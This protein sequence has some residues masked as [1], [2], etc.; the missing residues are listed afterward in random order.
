MK[1]LITPWAN[2]LENGG[3]SLCGFEYAE[4]THA[5]VEVDLSKK[6]R[7]FIRSLCASPL[8]LNPAATDT[9]EVKAHKKTTLE[10][11]RSAIKGNEEAGRTLAAI[12]L[13]T[14]DNYVRVGSDFMS[15]FNIVTLKDNEQPYIQNTT[16]SETRILYLS[17]DAEPKMVKAVRPTAE[18]AIELRQITTEPVWYRTRDIYKGQIADLAR[19]T[20]DIGFDLKNKF[21]REAYNLMITALNSGG[22]YGTFSLTG[23]KVSRLYVPNSLIDTS[24]LP[25]TNDLTVKRRTI[26]AKTNQVVWLNDD[27]TV[28]ASESAAD[29]AGYFGVP[30][31]QDIVRYCMGWAGVFS[32]GPLQPTGEIQVPA[33]DVQD[34]LMGLG[35]PTPNVMQTNAQEQIQ[36]NGFANIGEWFGVNWKIIPNVTIPS[37]TC[38]PKLN[39]TA[40]NV[41]LKPG[42]DEEFTE[43]DNKKHEETRWQTKV[44]GIA[45][46]AQRR[47]NMVRC[48]YK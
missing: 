37:G 27:D 32:D 48:T 8:D 23:S 13:E 33:I 29:I 18:T 1:N 26:N 20:F 2:R 41:Y 36:K 4:G 9:D 3:Q 25:T 14:V 11:I 45:I 42:M 43:T 16:K 44:F 22:P 35:T 15:Y 28:A 5:L 40:G 7:D 47:Y 17:E 34:I 46:I 10:I 39:K 19:A 6:T 30:V 21:D 12:R 24:Q 38:Y 31:L